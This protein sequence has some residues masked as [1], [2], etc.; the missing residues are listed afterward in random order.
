MSE[1]FT[2]SRSRSRDARR[3]RKDGDSTT[4]TT[5]THSDSDDHGGDKKR[6]DD[7]KKR[8]ATWEW[9]VLPLAFVLAVSGTC[10][11]RPVARP[12]IVTSMPPNWVV[13][14]FAIGACVAAGLAW[15][16]ARHAGDRR[17]DKKNKP[18]TTTTTTTTGDQSD[19]ESR[20]RRHEAHR[21]GLKK[22]ADIFYGVLLGAL[23]IWAWLY[24]GMQYSYDM[25]MAALFF[26]ILIAGYTLG[27]TF[28]TWRHTEKGGWCIIPLV[29]WLFVMLMW[30]MIEIEFAASS[31]GGSMGGAGDMAGYGG[32]LGVGLHMALGGGPQ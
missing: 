31:G 23:I 3:S 13:G 22:L 24:G 8:I 11:L 1:G 9:I 26:L 10:L 2:R 30:S 15:V 27:L 29:T 17:E 25:K 21:N 12:T 6:R 14:C 18:S 7:R 16:F 32:G 20:R 19:E 5:H 28:W 4:T